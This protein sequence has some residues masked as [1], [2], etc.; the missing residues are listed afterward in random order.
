MAKERKYARVSAM[1]MA[2]LKP[3]LLT[4][5]ALTVIAWVVVFNQARIND[6]LMTW[7]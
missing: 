2:A 6:L 1:T 5:T 4:S 3:W 7:M